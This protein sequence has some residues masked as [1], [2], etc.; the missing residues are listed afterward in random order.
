MN[1]ESEYVQWISEHTIDDN[2]I[3]SCKL[4]E[5]KEVMTVGTIKGRQLMLAVWRLLPAWLQTAGRNVIGAEAL[6]IRIMK[7]NEHV[8]KIKRQEVPFTPEPEP[9][10]GALDRVTSSSRF[11]TPQ[12]VS[13][14]IHP[15]C[16][17]I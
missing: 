11:A 6:R 12:V 2:K 7:D 16:P 13:L 17:S 1:V 3:K 10:D 14:S 4:M 15:L 9:E 8:K 5:V